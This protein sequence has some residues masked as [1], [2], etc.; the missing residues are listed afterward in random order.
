MIRLI[1]RNIH[2][3]ISDFPWYDR[4]EKS[5]R[6][7]ALI[8]NL[9]K[10]P[11]NSWLPRYDKFERSS[12]ELVIIIYFRKVQV[13]SWLFRD[14]IYWRKIRVNSWFSKTRINIACVRVTYT[15]ERKR[16][17]IGRNKREKWFVGTR[18]NRRRTGE[19]SEC[20]GQ[21]KR[22]TEKNVQARWTTRMGGFDER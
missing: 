10:V 13:N 3:I 2:V 15:W 19:R 12:R 1:Q 18:N 6:E 5:S 7:L 11:R 20:G 8:I 9:R 16:Q 21:S 17:I 4:F 14:I 22:I